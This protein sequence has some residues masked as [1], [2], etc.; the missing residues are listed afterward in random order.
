[1]KEMVFLSNP[2]QGFTAA[3]EACNQL[4]EGVLAEMVSCKEPTMFSQL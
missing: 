2:P 4:P 3:V 1:M